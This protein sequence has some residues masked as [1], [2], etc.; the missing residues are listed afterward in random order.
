MASYRTILLNPATKSDILAACI[1]ADAAIQAGLAQAEATKSSG[2]LTISAGILAFLAAMVG[3]WGTLRATKKQI[4][5]NSAEQ[6]KQRRYD[7]KSE[8]YY[9]A[10]KALATGLGA[11]VRMS[12]LEIRA[13]DVLSIYK[14]IR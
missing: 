10:V 1:Q 14:M 3:I 5:A 6:S 8:V 13:Q 2:Y 7:L 11:I 4:A 9:A 12:N